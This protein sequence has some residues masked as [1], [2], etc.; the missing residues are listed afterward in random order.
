MKSWMKAASS[1]GREG[2]REAT[3]QLDMAVLLEG[4]YP[5]GRNDTLT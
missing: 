1:G 4:N 3:V 5:Q 2:V